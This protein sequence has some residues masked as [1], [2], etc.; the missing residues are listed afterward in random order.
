MEAAEGRI[1]SRTDRK[2][3]TITLVALVVHEQKGVRHGETG[4]NGM[5]RKT[6]NQRR[7]ALR[8]GAQ[9]NLTNFAEY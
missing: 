9:A 3:L 1:P 6:E 8:R 7:R 5:S 2:R 4:G